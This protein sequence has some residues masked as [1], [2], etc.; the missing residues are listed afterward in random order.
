MVP[1]HPLVYFGN[2]TGQHL[3]VAGS[4]FR[5]VE[6][7]IHESLKTSLN[8]HGPRIIAPELVERKLTQ[9]CNKKYKTTRQLIFLKI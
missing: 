6:V 9:E 5:Y 1:A 7:I 4:K 8:I 3:D 2:Y